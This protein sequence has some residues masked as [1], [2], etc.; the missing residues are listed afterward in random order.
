MKIKNKVTK[1]RRKES[2]NFD[3]LIKKKKIIMATATSMDNSD[4]LWRECVDWLTRCKIIPPDHNVN[5]DISLLAKTLRDGVLL[6]NLLVHLDKNSIDVRDYHKKPQ[7]AQVIN[8]FPS[9]SYIA[10]P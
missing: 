5:S 8:N 6:C 4:F 9:Y 1:T 10:N 2:E 3:L 7:G